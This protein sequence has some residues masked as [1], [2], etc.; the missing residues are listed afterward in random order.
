MQIRTERVLTVKE[1]HS[2]TEPIL[3]PGEIVHIGWNAA[4]GVLVAASNK[5]TDLSTL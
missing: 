2:A 4:D 5:A 3:K 1:P